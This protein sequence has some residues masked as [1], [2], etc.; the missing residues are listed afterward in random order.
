MPRSFA[1]CSDGTSMSHTE[2]FVR[3]RSRTGQLIEQKIKGSSESEALA[4]IRQLGLTPISV[5][6]QPA[7]WNTLA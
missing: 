7:G 5:E 6:I 4:R 3:A 2:Y 1:N